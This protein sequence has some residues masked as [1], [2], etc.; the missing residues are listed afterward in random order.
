MINS[1]FAF[2]LCPWQ[3]DI[4]FQEDFGKAPDELFRKFDPEPIA[5]AS[6]AQVHKA[7]LHDGTPVAVKVGTAC[8]GVCLQWRRSFLLLLLVW[9]DGFIFPTG[10]IHRPQGSLCGRHPNLGIPL[11]RRRAHAPQLWIPMGA[12]GWHSELGIAWDSLQFKSSFKY[13]WSIE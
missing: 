13:F 9:K 2:A 7:E 12:Q 5:A 6:L 4:L 8:F 3:V 1:Y 10:A 11:G